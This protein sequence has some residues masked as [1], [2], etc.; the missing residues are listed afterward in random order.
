MNKLI[1][2]KIWGTLSA[3][4]RRTKTKSIVAVAYFGN[5]GAR[6]LPLRKD[7]IL[8]VDASEGAV[9]SGQ[10]SPQELLKLYYKG[11][12]IYSKSCLHA[13]I[14]IL[15]NVVFIGSANVSNHSKKTLKEILF[16]TNDRTVIKEAKEF[17][18]SFCHVPFGD[19]KL[20][21]LQKIYRPPN[22]S[23]NKRI[24]HRK[25]SNKSFD[26]PLFTVQLEPHDYDDE[27]QRHSDKGNAEIKDKRKNKSRHFV[28]EFIIEGR[29]SPKKNDYIVMVEKIGNN[30]FVNPVGQIIHKHGW[31][32]GNVKKTIGFVELPDKNRKNLKTINNKLTPLER[33][34]IMKDKKQSKSFTDKMLSLWKI[35]F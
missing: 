22:F 33:K 29:F 25:P 19:E 13:K 18:L 12:H 34:Y 17:I 16:K 4:A 30:Y 31:K 8:L 7:S 27:E 11:V 15:G 35:K 26:Y 9:K 2:R 24:K 32:S 21:K 1:T 20:K 28:D 6:L 5:G 23:G 10:T 3:H 14:Y